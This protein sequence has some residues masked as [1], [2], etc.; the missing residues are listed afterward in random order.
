M[1]PSAR[2]L[3]QPW[4]KPFL[5]QTS[6]CPMDPALREEKQG[7]PLN[8]IPTPKRTLHR[9]ACLLPCHS[10]CCPSPH[11][12]GL[13]LFLSQCWGDLID[14]VVQATLGQAYAPMGAEERELPTPT[15]PRRSLPNH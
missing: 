8:T 14:Q 11:P 1:P 9:N 2:Y 12:E 4:L 6:V 7:P 3:L 13:Y 10:P 5:S 15:T